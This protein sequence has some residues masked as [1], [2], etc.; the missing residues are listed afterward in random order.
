MGQPDITEIAAGLKD[1]DFLNKLPQELNGFSLQPSSGIKG[2][3]LNIASYVNESMRCRLDLTYTCETFDYVPLKTVGLHVYREERLFC[4]D[5][6]K[7]AQL[8]L[9][10]LPRLLHEVDR[11]QKHSMD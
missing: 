4:R 7:F 6:D 9:E 10:Q 1:C 3:I 5:R 2:Q 11:A 8:V